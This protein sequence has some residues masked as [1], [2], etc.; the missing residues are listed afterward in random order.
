LPSAP[1]REKSVVVLIRR[2]PVGSD[3]AAEALRVALGQ[4]LASNRVTVAFLDDG[5]WSARPL[6]PEVVQGADCAKPIGFLR[7][8][9][10][11]LVADAE[12]LAAREIQAVLPGV[13]VKP[14]RE[15]LDLLT[16]ADAV[17]AY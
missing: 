3:R 11:R 6:R 10:H 14:R 5:V 7:E 2:A 13:D 16:A 17:I 1:E 12:S 9:G 4:T 15:L 8:L